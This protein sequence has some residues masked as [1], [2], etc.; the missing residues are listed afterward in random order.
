M[1]NIRAS[2]GGSVENESPD[3]ASIPE[4]WGPLVQDESCEDG[5]SKVRPEGCSLLGARKLSL[6]VS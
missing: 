5:V 4:E 3:L 1:I 6:V 2:C